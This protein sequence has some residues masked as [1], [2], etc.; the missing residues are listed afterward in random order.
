MHKVIPMDAEA[1]SYEMEFP[2]EE[3]VKTEKRGRKAVK[4]AAKDAKEE[5]TVKD[6]KTKETVPEKKSLRSQSDEQAITDLPGVGA[7][8]AEK[9]IMAGFDDL[10]SIAV[11]TPGQIVD[12]A[13]VT[14]VMARKLIKAAQGQPRHGFPIRHGRAREAREPHQDLNRRQGF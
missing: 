10:M 14:D 1:I 8:T 6:E 2:Q 9:L 3:D 11:A 13:G 5:R 12:A 4:E 7:A